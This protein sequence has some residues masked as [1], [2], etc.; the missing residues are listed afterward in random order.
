MIFSIQFQCHRASTQT[1]LF[2]FK[3]CF[4]SPPKIKFQ[5]FRYSDFMMS[6][7]KKYIL[8]NNFG[9]IHCVNVKEK[10]TKKLYKICD[11]KTSPRPFYL[12]KELGPTS[13][14]KLIFLRKLFTLDMEQRN[15][16]LADLLRFLFTEDFLEI[17]KGLEL[18]SR[19]DFSQNFSVKSFLL[20][21]YVIGQISLPDCLLP[22][23]FSEMCLVF[24]VWPFDD[25]I[26]FEYLKS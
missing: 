22:K 6:N 12:C 3:S 4:R 13:I 5:N 7:F 24:H 1:C 20:Q 17:E 23:L 25:V 11:L 10:F 15:Y 16:Q 14:G 26:T 21:Y 19:P 8:L 2:R 18:F 9:S